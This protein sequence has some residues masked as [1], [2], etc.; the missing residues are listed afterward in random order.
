MLDEGDK[1]DGCIGCGI[2]IL[3]AAI[4]ILLWLYTI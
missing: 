1:Q 3:F 2:L 4:G